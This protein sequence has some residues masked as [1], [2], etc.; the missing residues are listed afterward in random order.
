M[1]KN[2]KIWLLSVLA[3]A[4]A[5][6]NY[7]TDQLLRLG[8]FYLWIGIEGKNSKYKKL[9]GV[10]TKLLVSEL[11]RHGIH[12]LG[13]TIIGL[14]DHTPE[15]IDSIINWAVDHH[16]DFQQFMLYMPLPATPFY[17]QLKSEDR[18]LS[19]EEL[20]FADAHGQ[21]K[22]NYM[23]KH[24]KPG[25]ETEFLLRAFKRDFDVNGPSLTRMIR[26]ALN[27][28][29][30]YKNC[31]NPRMRG[32]INLDTKELSTIYAAIVWATKE[33][34]QANGKTHI[35]NQMHTLLN[36]IYREFGLKAKLM[37]PIVGRILYFTLKREEKRLKRGITY[38]PPTFYEKNERAL[39]LGGST[40]FKSTCIRFVV[41]V[42]ETK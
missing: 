27:G 6:K 15:N 3:S 23:H 29:L 8:V 30:T 42:D 25:Q 20:P 13:S 36:D 4:N 17:E 35:E 18:L 14:E 10:D 11:Q 38:E 39:K 26:T 9:D 12:V 19:E 31:S 41:P 33:W 32:I 22:F 28:W 21:F 1:E 37:A 7:T 16:T 5:I 24:I 40:K 2:N 34:A